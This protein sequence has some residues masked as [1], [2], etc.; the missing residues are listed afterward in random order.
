MHLPPRRRRL[1]AITWLLALLPLGWAGY[2]CTAGLPPTA[3][4]TPEAAPASAAP[5]ATPADATP[6]PGSAKNKKKKAVPVRTGPDEPGA[7]AQFVGKTFCG[8]PACHGAMMQ[9][10]QSLRHSHYLSD[11]KFKDAAGC[12]VCHGPAS[13]HMADPEHRLIP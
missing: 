8:A 1:H 2:C 5:T 6:A 13:D 7:E 9:E 12:E 10:F 3:A 11:P 4:Q